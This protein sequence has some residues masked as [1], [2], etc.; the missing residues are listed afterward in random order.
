MSSET[1]AVPDI[2][3]LR[4]SENRSSTVTRAWVEA[5]SA[6]LTKIRQKIICIC[7]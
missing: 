7:L 5:S 1:G 2:G 6:P 3:T 4:V